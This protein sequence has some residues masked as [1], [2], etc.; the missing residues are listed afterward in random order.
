MVKDG[1]L[2][3]NKLVAKTYRLTRRYGVPLHWSR[4]K[5][6]KFNVHTVCVL[7]V[8]FQ[9]E[10]KD[11]RLFAGWL[12]IATALGLQDVPHWTTLQKA[13]R[14]LP[15]RLIRSLMQLSGQ[16]K[17]HIIALDPT[18]YQL[19]NPSKGYCRRINRD[20]RKDALRKAS[21]LVTTNKKMVVD[22]YVTAK[23]RHGMKD[24]PYI[25]CPAT[26]NGRTILADKEFD[27]E[28]FHQIVEDAGGTS[29][30]PPKYPNV[31]IWRTKGKHRKELKA[32]GIPRI[33]RKRVLS[34][35]NNS[36]VKRRFSSVLRGRTFWQQA[37]DLYGKYLAYNLC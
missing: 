6:E 2:S 17:D 13:F 34:E 23:E 7:F 9:I 24:I 21:V 11:Y 3:Y 30:V 19:T 27:A 20:P 16:C 15:P 35:S 14:R 26:C 31:P 5:N 4:T 1:V 10:Q 12:S 32:R 29:I 22:V 28:S 36:A 33:F 8:L 18:Y 25:I 37:R